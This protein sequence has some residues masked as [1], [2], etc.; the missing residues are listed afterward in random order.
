MTSQS[1]VP[2]FVV[3]SETPASNATRSSRP[4]VWEFRNCGHHASNGPKWSTQWRLSPRALDQLTRCKTLGSRKTDQELVQPC[5]KRMESRNGMDTT[6]TNGENR[7]RTASLK[8]PS[9]IARVVYSRRKKKP[10]HRSSPPKEKKA[11]ISLKPTP[12]L[13]HRQPLISEGRLYR[14]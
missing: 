13:S 14:T 12:P 5:L 6:T 10:S 3:V 7:N 11:L 8:S 2:A 1:K 9:I 4:S